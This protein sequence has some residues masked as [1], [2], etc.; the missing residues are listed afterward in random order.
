MPR[1]QTALDQ[2]RRLAKPLRYRLSTDP[3]GFPLIPGRYGRIECFDG[4]ELTVYC[5]HLR[6]FTKIWAIPG[7]RRYQTGD[8]EMRAIVRPEALNQV[9]SLI[10]AK[11]WGGRGRG[12]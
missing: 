1:E 9:A 11:R 12:C 8:N 4:R 5:D 7:V 6:L 10:R 2:L 3:A